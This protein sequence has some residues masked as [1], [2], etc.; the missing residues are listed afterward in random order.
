MQQ[1]M[2]LV[3][4]LLITLI[5]SCA[6]Q[7][8]EPISSNQNISSN[9]LDTLG[10]RSSAGEWRK[11]EV[12]LDQPA[13]VI[14]LGQ[15]GQIAIAGQ[16]LLLIS[17]DSGQTWRAISEGKGSNMY[18]TDGKNFQYES[19]GN[20]ISIAKLCSVEKALFSHSGRLYLNST[21]DHS[22][23]LWS[24]PTRNVSDAWY[25]RAFAPSPEQFEK[26]SDYSSPGRSLVSTNGRVLVNG[27]FSNETVLLKSEDDGASWLPLWRDP[28][29]ARIVDFDFLDEQNGWM[30]QADG[31]LF[32]TRD[33]GSTWVSISTL[34]ANAIGRVVS[35]D[36]VNTTKGFIVGIEGLILTTND[37]GQHWQQ[38]IV[39]TSA[40]LSRVAA[41]D[42][43]KAWVVGERGTL[44]ETSDGG[45]TWQKHTLGVDEDIQTI[46]VK[47]GKAWLVAGRD[48]YRSN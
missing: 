2:L 8:K 3:A 46:S 48:V 33:G 26:N 22:V 1:S 39:G 5:V 37:G 9:V 19:D 44:L 36:F 29:A 23:V 15:Q 11:M 35:A 47:E 24:V 27:T 40:S 45:I 16:G 30:L 43:K 18:T 21:C 14:A 4:L 17:L 31:K 25:V 38:P 42:E 41:L 10:E 12:P 32:R 6:I 13:D 28:R 7:R 20:S 34:P